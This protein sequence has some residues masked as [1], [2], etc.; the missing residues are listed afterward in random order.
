[1]KFIPLELQGAY[2][3]YGIHTSI[4]AVCTN[5]Q[6]GTHKNELSFLCQMLLMFQTSLLLYHL[7]VKKQG[8]ILPQRK[9]MG[10]R[11]HTVSQTSVH[12]K[13]SRICALP[14]K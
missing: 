8:T 14:L 13:D 6:E 5:E 12:D 4:F 11:K 1:M 2:P 7:N 3:K 10:Q 9:P